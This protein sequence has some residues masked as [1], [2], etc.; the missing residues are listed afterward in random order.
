GPTQMFVPRWQLFEY[1][2]ISKSSGNV[3][4]PLKL[5]EI[6]G[7]D[8]LR[9]S[10]ARVA[11]FGQDGNASAD[12]LHERYERELGNDLGNLVSRTTAMIARYRGGT[13]A[14]TPGEGVF[15]ADALREA[16]VER[17]DRFD[18]TG[19]LEEIW[20]AVRRLNQHVEASAP[21]E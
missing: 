3:I 21:W 5:T 13:L 12:D 7:I 17:L 2:T 10:A 19:A 16:L 8:A 6:Y 20:Q 1:R 4:Q 18:I 15:D 14:K 11:R 9:F